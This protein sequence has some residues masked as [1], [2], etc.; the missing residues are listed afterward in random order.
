MGSK[1]HRF[2]VVPDKFRGSLS[3]SQASHSIKMGLT[4]VFKDAQIT[5]FG[6]TD[7][8][9]GFVD[10]IA[11]AKK[12][13]KVIRL[14]TIDPTGQ[15]LTAKCALLDDNTA[16][17]GLTEA[18]GI[19]LVSETERNPATL[20]NIGTG[21]I[22]AKLVDRGYKTI[23]IG[24]GGSA[25]NDGGIGLL[26]PLGFKFLDKNGREIEPNGAG[27]AHLAKIE[28]PDTEFKTKFIVATDVANTLLGENGASLGFAEQKGA[29]RQQALELEKNMK[30]YVEVVKKC[31]G[32]SKHA[33]AGTGSAGGCAYS[34][35]NFLDAE[36]VSGF[37]LFAKYAD[38]EKCVKACDVVVTGEGKFDI[39]DMHGKGPFELVKLALRHKKQAWILC[40]QSEV[41]E[42]G[43]KAMGIAGAKI[44]QILPLAPNAVEAQN[45]APKFLS[46]LAKEFASKLK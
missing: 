38:I 9:D 35:M 25:T 33:E 21:Q 29:T 42:N 7:G 27:L 17:V 44:G 16:L 22:L 37:D 31:F 14:K 6:M 28:K 43:L 8:G 41:D 45:R 15:T 30:N 4:A 19:N 34:L 13:A 32:K 1:V 10:T 23:I 5:E 3:A 36:R 39:T 12:G 2:L 11:K 46:A 20:T 18:S 24:V 26:V 40:G